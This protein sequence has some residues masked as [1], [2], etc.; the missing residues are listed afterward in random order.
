MERIICSMCERTRRSPFKRTSPKQLPWRLARYLTH[1]N[2]PV[3]KHMCMCARVSLLSAIV[4]QLNVKVVTQWLDLEPI[5]SLAESYNK[6]ILLCSGLFGSLED[7]WLLNVCAEPGSLLPF[8]KL[9]APLIL[10]GRQ[11]TL[12]GP[13]AAT[14]EMCHPDLRKDGDRG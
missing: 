2:N 14:P 3:H 7:R 10:V 6:L 13:L 12:A 4:R 9:I 1:L 5:Q 11:H 8:R